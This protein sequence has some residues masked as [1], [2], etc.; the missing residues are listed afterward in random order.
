[1]REGVVAAG[2]SGNE[3]DSFKEQKYDGYTPKGSERG[4]AVKPESYAGARPSG[5]EGL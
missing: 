1:M 2:I 5:R 4:Q 3:R